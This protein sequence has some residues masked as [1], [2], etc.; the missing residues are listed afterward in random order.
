MSCQLFPE[1]FGSVTE[2]LKE[3]VTHNVENGL[4]DPKAPSLL[5]ADKHNPKWGCPFVRKKNQIVVID[6]VFLI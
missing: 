5:I 1:E 2:I 4:N 6:L 3:L